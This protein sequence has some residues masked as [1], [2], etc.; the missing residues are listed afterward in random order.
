MITALIVIYWILTICCALSA[1]Y[2]GWVTFQLRK[3]NADGNFGEF[4]VSIVF[5]IILN[6]FATL[7]YFTAVNL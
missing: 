7:F 2:A 4:I 5:T 6:L 3:K 1:T